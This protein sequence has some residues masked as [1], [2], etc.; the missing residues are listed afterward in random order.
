[1][2]FLKKKKN[3]L[4]AFSFFLP[5]HFQQLDTFSSNNIITKLNK[6][7]KF[8]QILLPFVFRFWKSSLEKPNIE[9]S[10]KIFYDL[11]LFHLTSIWFYYKNI[12]SITF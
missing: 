11:E 1:M 10:W 2:G 3:N 7:M 4:F 8:S 12:S 9:H 5:Y 6:S